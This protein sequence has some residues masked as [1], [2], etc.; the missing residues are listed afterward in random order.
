[1]PWTT[2]RE[3]WLNESTTTPHTVFYEI[4]NGTSLKGMNQLFAWSSNKIS[5]W[6]KGKKFNNKNRLET[7]SSYTIV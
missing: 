7:T 4:C 6:E 2:L 3:V 1:V 5:H